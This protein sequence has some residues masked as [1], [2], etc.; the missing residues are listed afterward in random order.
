M[1]NIK[2]L[3]NI[4][5]NYLNSLGIVDI[6]NQ[7]EQ[8]FNPEEYE[9]KFDIDN[10]DFK[11]KINPLPDNFDLDNTSISG[12][13]ETEDY[14]YTHKNLPKIPF[15]ALISG[16]RGSGKT[17][18]TTSLLKFIKPFIH[19]VI[20]YSPTAELDNK[21]KNT[22]KALNLEWKVGDNIFFDYDEEV[23][24]KQI[25]ELK[26]INKGKQN[27]RD[28][29]RVFFIF[30]DIIDD[31]PKNKKNTEFNK[32]LLNNR[33]YAASVAIITQSY[34]LL[35]R[36][37]R[38]NCSQILLWK[39]ENQE[40]IENYIRELSGCLGRTRK[41]SKDR[42]LELYEFATSKPHSF[43]YINYHQPDKEERYHRN[44]KDILVFE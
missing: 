6:N 3:L 21:W 43:L 11:K 28:K 13:K 16:A 8:N 2:N 18:A 4:D 12:S 17:Y 25:R 26:K 35:D 9:A 23:L 5:D 42:F 7:E 38:F 39:S 19:K 15:S 20:L 44:W 31:L 10:I 34:M 33:H 29:F 36:K 30:D 24:Q 14:I 22:F 41:E 37:F 32:L 40:E 27:I 1:D